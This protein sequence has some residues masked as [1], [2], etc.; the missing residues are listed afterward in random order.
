MSDDCND[1]YVH[2]LLS[3]FF[4]VLLDL[5]CS[6]LH[7][8]NGKDLDYNYLGLGVSNSS[9]SSVTSIYVYRCNKYFSG[10][11]IETP[12][13]IDYMKAKLKYSR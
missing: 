2:N 9:K 1:T 4:F 3:S 7:V 11:E 5:T 10:K 12:T 13:L 6:I 8:L